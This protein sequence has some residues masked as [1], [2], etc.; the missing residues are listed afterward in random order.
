MK[1]TKFWMCLVG[2]LLVLALA[3]T[4]ILWRLVPSG[5][6]AE[7]T[8][9]GT[10]LR[11]INLEQVTQPET[12]TVEGPAGT[13]IIEVEP[14]RIRVQSADCPDQVCVHQGWIEDGITPIVCLPNRLVITLTGGED[15]GIDGAAR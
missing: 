7:I 8:L 9:D 6:V 15:P 13:N 1:S 4:L 10:V 11:R 14:G 3:A 12:F 2:V 5:P